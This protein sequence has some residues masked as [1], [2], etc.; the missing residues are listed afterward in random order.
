MYGLEKGLYCPEDEHDAC[1]VG[2][3]VNIS[4]SKYHDIIE[5]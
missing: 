3:V 2:L 5:C 4:G 1:G